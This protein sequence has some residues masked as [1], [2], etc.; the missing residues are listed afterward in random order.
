MALR[1]RRGTDAERQLITPLEGELIYTVD[2]KLLWIGDGGTVGGNLVTGGAGT[3]TALSGLTDV[4]LAGLQDGQ[5]LQYN[6]LSGNWEPLTLNQ[7]TN[8]LDDLTD[9]V[10]PAPNLNEVLAWD[11]LNWTPQ[12]LA[13]TTL[14]DL[15]DVLAS[16]P[17]L[18]QVLAY[19]GNNWTP[20]TFATSLDQLTDVVTGG[21]TQ[22]DFLVYDGLNWIPQSDA[23]V[24]LLNILGDLKG[25]VFADDS[26]VL[27]DG[28]NGLFR[29]GDLTINGARISTETDPLTILSSNDIILRAG[30]SQSGFG[31][32]KLQVLSEPTIGGSILTAAPN[33]VEIYSTGG[34][35]LTP[36]DIGSGDLTGAISFVN[37]QASG[38]QS[39]VFIGTQADPTGTTDA[40]HVPGKLYIATAGA[41]SGDGYNLLT[42]DTFGQLAIGKETATAKLD[43][44]GAIKPGVYADAAARDA[45]ITAPVAGMMVFVTDG[46]GAGN[47][48][49]HGYTGVGWV[50]LN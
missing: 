44:E 8:Q 29:T 5:L 7:I 37:A 28:V 4:N 41:T 46:D 22:G 12:A 13:T 26:T 3:P 49:F 14:N 10:A 21:A 40:S 25:S 31:R 45:A 16:N 24:G 11:G 27:V 18:N 20:Q 48:Q 9:V 38:A 32:L 36:T 30:G 50:S 34:D 43:V 15:T 33:T 42:F 23:E 39:Y 1:L 17:S 19:D 47:P 6:A 35:F 2:T